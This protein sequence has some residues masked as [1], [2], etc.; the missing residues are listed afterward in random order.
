MYLGFF[1]RF[2]VICVCGVV[3]VA[4]VFG[5]IYELFRSH[6]ALAHCFCLC[7]CMYFGFFMGCSVRIALSRLAFIYVRA[8][9]LGSSI[10]LTLFVFAVL[11]RLPMYLRFFMNCS[12][13]IALPRFTF[14]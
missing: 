8:C 3:A 2:D 1:A 13:L 7:A 12:V 6:R 14:I 5:V 4:N 11:L 9:I 10:A